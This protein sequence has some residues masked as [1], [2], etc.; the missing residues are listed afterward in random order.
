MTSQRTTLLLSVTTLIAVLLPAAVLSEPVLVRADGIT[1]PYTLI[2]DALGGTRKGYDVPDCNHTTFGDHITQHRDPQLDRFVF[3]F[4]LHV[5]F[6]DDRCERFDRQRNEVK[7][8]APSPA[9]LKALEGETVSYSWNFR[10]TAGVQMS[11]EFTHIHQVNPSCV[12]FVF[13]PLSPE[14]R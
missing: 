14:R 5:D 7:T 11:K 2:N 6:D 8:Y 13:N 1:R 9:Y 12:S 10:L 3:A 4:H